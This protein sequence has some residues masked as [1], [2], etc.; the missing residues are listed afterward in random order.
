MRHTVAFVEFVPV[1]D[2]GI[3]A[4]AALAIMALLALYLILGAVEAFFQHMPWPLN[5]VA[6]LAASAMRWARDSVAWVFDQALHGL[7]WSVKALVRFWEDLYNTIREVTYDLEH[8]SRI[9]KHH[10]IPRLNRQLRDRINQANR[11]TRNWAVNLIAAVRLQLQ[12]Q[13]DRLRHD[14]TADVK[15]LDHRITTVDKSLSHRIAALGS[16]LRAE[17]AR[18]QHSLR[19][20]ITNVSQR[21]TAMIVSRFDAAEALARSLFR[22]AETDITDAKADAEAYTDRVGARVLR[23]A[24]DTV[25]REAHRAEENTW[26]TV[27]AMIGTLEKTIGNDFPDL[28]RLLQE[29]PTNVPADLTAAIAAAVRFMPPVLRTMDDCVIP[30]CRDLGPTRQLLHDMQLPITSVAL[31][32][33]F[34]QMVTHPEAWADE[35]YAFL[36]PLVNAEYDI[37]SGFLGL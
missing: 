9:I 35:T 28:T 31:I 11:Y 34:I 17:I 29:I 23:E 25:D 37:L 5:T 6:G 8:A 15:R 30:Q 36:N 7:T 12:R 33:W 14:L 27:T 26:P 32:A 21:L 18:V 16:S 1:V 10:D 20:E 19:A 24:L 13:I 2:L 22:Q 3:A 4:G